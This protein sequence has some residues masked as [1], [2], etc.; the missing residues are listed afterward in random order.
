MYKMVSILKTPQ[1]LH[2]CAV[3]LL[4]SG[5]LVLVSGVVL[6]VLSFINSL[7]SNFSVLR[8]EGVLGLVLG[9]LLIVGAV[10]IFYKRGSMDDPTS[11]CVDEM[12]TEIRE[13]N[14]LRYVQTTDIDLVTGTD[15]QVQEVIERSNLPYKHYTGNVRGF[16]G[17][18][19]NN[20]F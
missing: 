15:M 13:Q 16:P 18:Y 5:S 1:S 11:Y 9:L 7:Q 6:L 8:W 12:Q 3:F 17:G 14:T 19:V 10:I 2:R 4:I 20:I